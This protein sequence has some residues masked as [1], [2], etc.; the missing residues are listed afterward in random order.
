LER[1][2][3]GA[4]GLIVVIGALCVLSLS[5][6]VAWSPAGADDQSSLGAGRYPAAYALTGAKVVAAPGKTYEPGTIVIRRGII[7]SVGL[8]KDVTV[9]YDAETIDGKGLVVYPGFI[10]LYTT[11]GQRAGVERSAT[12]KGRSVDLAEAPLPSTPPDN[13]RGLTPEFEVASALELPDALV[14][15]RRRLGFTD[16]LSAPAGAIATGQSALVSLSGL[17]RREVIVKAPVALHINLAPPAAPATGAA[18]P[19]V[20]VP[21]P[22]LPPGISPFRRRGFI[23]TTEPGEN[24]YPRVLMGSIAH[25]RQAMLDSDHHQKLDAYYKTH[26]GAQPPYDPALLAL[27]AARSK[28]LAVWWEANTRDEIHRA[29]DLAA[30][31]GTSAVIVGGREAAKVADRLKVEKVPVVIQLNFP[32]EPKVPTEADYRKR[33]AAERDEP[34]KV[35]AHKSARW[36]EHVAT[37]AALAKAGVPFAFSTEGVER[38]DGFPGILRQ[39]VT[40]GLAAEDALAGLTRQAA[41]IAQVDRRLGT[42][43]PGKLGHLIVMT[44]PFS[45]EKAKV[46]FVLIDGL[47][48]E[49]K[50]EDRARAR[51]KAGGPDGST[52]AGKGGEPDSEKTDRP[53]DSKGD[54]PV[55][56]GRPTLVR[57]D[58]DQKSKP[59]AGALGKAT[60]ARATPER[61]GPITKDQAKV[62]RGTSLSSVG[63]KGGSERAGAKQPPREAEPS[64]APAAANK[65][66]AAPFVDVAVELDDDRKPAIH[67]GG[68][69]LIEG[70][71]I[72]T[73]TRGTIA[74]GSILVK[75]GKIKAVGTGLSAPKGVMVLRAAGLVAM[76]GIIDTHSHIA[77]QGGVNE[78]SLSIV[79][80][81][82]IKDVVRGEDV[83]IYRALAGGTTT[84]RLLHGSANA[85]G[86]QDAVIK[87]K[88]G[89]PGRELIVRGGPQGV[90]FALGENVTRSPRRFPN[91]RMGVESVIE[92]AFD[93]GQAYRALW[94]HYRE[95]LKSSSP[96]RSGPP[97]RVDLRLETLSG[98]LD[99]S[100]K[101]HSHCYRSDEILMLLRTVA[102][103]GVR[104][105]SLQHVLE[106]YKVAAEIA[107]HGASASTFSDWWAYKIEA[108][109][110]IPYNAALLTEAGASVCIK[111]DD[112]ELMRHLNLEAAKMVKYGGVSEAQALAMITINPARELGLD[113]RLGSIEVGK[114]ADIVLFNGHPLD[115][116][117]RCE[118]ALIDGEVY[119]ER[120]EPGGGFAA[121]AGDHR[122][123]PAA[124]ESIRNRSIEIAAQPKNLFALVGANLHPVA[125]AE[126]KAG[127]LVLGGGRIAAI[128][129]AGTPI[130][131]EAQT[132]DLSGLDIWPGMVDAGST[133]GLFEIGSLNETQDH[134]DAAQFQPE[135][136]SS[137]ALHADS[138][139]IPVTRVNGILTALVE[140]SGG[141][142]AGQGCLIDLNGWVPREL[143]IADPAALNVRIPAYISPPTDSARP[144][145]GPG[146]PGPGPG[147]GGGG[148]AA[149]AIEQRKER[150]D[151][152]KELFRRAVAYDA[153]VSKARQRRAPPPAPDLR[154]EA[155]LPYATG[156][157]PVVFHAEA[158]GEISDALAI[159]RELKLKAILS[160]AAEAWKVVDQIKAAKVPVLLGGTLNLPRRE[161]DPYDSAYACAAKL[162]AAGVTVGIRSKSSGETAAR[163]LPFEAATAVAF[164]LPED[165]ALRAVTLTPAQVLGVAD[166]VGSLETGKRANVVVTAGNLLQPTTPVL[167]LFIDGE[168]VRP[169]SRHTQLYA[170]YRRR[171]DEVR[172]GR[173]R[174]GIDQAPTKI[175]GAG[176]AGFGSARTDSQPQ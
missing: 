132:I 20:P 167:A 68:D 74:G 39:L 51:S 175:S 71:T 144:G 100:I 89:K 66:P 17:P 38:I 123:M 94:D 33:P 173:A 54:R 88:Y 23:A 78:G 95:A 156:L 59:V 67:T 81:V 46:R 160:G 92:R 149:A 104:V 161:Y 49:I 85:I 82:R 10:D 47:K 25:L 174:L 170:K 142:I 136:R 125:G 45:D 50:P 48:F 106:G 119:F 130:P 65:P 63:Q 137:T 15:A 90:K 57:K 127:T 140:P 40:A 108:Y 138:E 14:A 109:D 53:P 31:F 163:N 69:V 110:A 145:V 91:T 24:P 117:S 105:Q 121:R 72:L 153:V 159:A 11:A 141:I 34:L 157:K 120:Y 22:G 165:V 2:S 96:E 75:D 52:P 158:A 83:A 12:G 172:A 9:P 116:F 102:R 37:A 27:Q 84:A 115:A 41:A 76:P 176:S 126:I 148:D 42:L 147:P 164:G 80:E 35:L 101:I 152:I 56:E 26:G 150:L 64:K 114:D 93:E 146:R 28:R 155:L 168:P 1:A 97:P 162:H 6:V 124:P 19:A 143:V 122:A 70:A 166:Q 13:R 8:A 4:R 44:A 131:P 112:A 18:A 118:L 151:Q 139:H 16:F 99:G 107:A 7:E 133:I 29:L 79:P 98:I 77:V 135:L 43:E 86:G 5:L 32:A 169:E 21:T 171:L 62:P 134:T 129:P 111:S 128:G 154:L 3:A 61:A 30:E 58:A 60:A 55:R 73:V 113:G 87:L 36:K 103:Y